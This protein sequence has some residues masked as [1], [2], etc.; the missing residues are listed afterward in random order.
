MAEGGCVRTESCS[1]SSR[2]GGCG[3]GAVVVVDVVVDGRRRR[4]TLVDIRQA[5]THSPAN[6]AAASQSASALSLPGFPVLAVSLF[7]VNNKTMESQSGLPGQTKIFVLQQCNCRDDI[8]KIWSMSTAPGQRQRLFI[9][10]DSLPPED[11][12]SSSSTPEGHQ[13]GGWGIA[14]A[15]R[16]ATR[17]DLVVQAKSDPWPETPDCA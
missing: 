7:I 3:G 13:L 5:G 2:G 8:L 12:I 16:A 1:S 15:G 10:A 14:A 4:M 9:S 6:T 11:R 17:G